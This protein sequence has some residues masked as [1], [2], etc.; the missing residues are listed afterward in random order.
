VR[1]EVAEAQD[2]GGDNENRGDPQVRPSRSEVGDFG[3]VG[4]RIGTR[5]V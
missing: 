3:F 1:P 4:E 2:R 5:V